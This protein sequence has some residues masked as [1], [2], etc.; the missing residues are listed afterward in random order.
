MRASDSSQGLAAFREVWCCDF[1]F[2]A[3]PG[4]RPRPL[5]LVAREQHTGR[6]LRH[7]RDALLRQRCAP[8][9]TGPDALFVAYFA[10]AELGCFLELGWSLPVHVLD[11]YV[12]H[13]CETNGLPS[14]CGNGLIGALALR[15]LAHID[16]GEKEAMRRLILDHTAWS[17]NEQTEILQYCASDVYALAALL[18]RMAPSVDWPRALLRGRFM[19]AVARME[20]AGVPIDAALHGALVEQW[21]PIKRT[22]IEEVDASYRVYEGTTFRSTRFLSYLAAQ[23]IPWP[24]LPSGAPALDE[25]T[26]RDQALAHPEIEPLHALRCSLADLRLSG[27]EIGRDGRNRCLL[28][29]FSTITGRNA[30]SNTKFVFG[31]ARW[32]RGLICPPE[33]YGLVA[34]DW[35]AQEVALVAALSGDE[36]MIEG[37]ASDP[38]LAFAKAARLVPKDA[39]KQSHPTIREQCKAIVLGVGYGMEAPAMAARAG[40]RP[41]EAAELLRLHRQTYCTFWRWSD[42]TVSGAMLTG[43]MRTVFGWRRRIGREVNVRSL[44]NWPAQAHGAEMLRLACIA[45]T[46]AGIEV[47]API[48]DA[49]LIVAPLDRLEEQARH[50]CEIMA[51]ASRAVTGRLTL[52]VDAR[53]VSWPDRY[54]DPRG[55]DMWD[56]VMRL[57]GSVGS[58]G[59]G[60]G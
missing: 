47:V 17:D 48:H 53:L 40:I 2:H 58:S 41:C 39:T 3:D 31:P 7:W 56:R 4:E 57:L 52:R 55:A 54:Q 5:C 37:Y 36:Q 42:E 33:G 9:H 49:I 12:E 21:I 10:S 34:L 16:A 18:P 24:R 46:E 43:E 11:L 20:R 44:M 22:L 23:E 38:Y 50:T 32:L 1:E 13:R 19:A 14:P 29:P 59:S 15:G 30:P 60:V 28:S 51:Q 8:F 35:A 6:E 45:A 25:T 27:L 26:F